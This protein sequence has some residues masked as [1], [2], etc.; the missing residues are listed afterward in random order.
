MSIFKYRMEQCDVS[1]TD[2]LVRFREKLEQWNDLLSGDESHAISGQFADMMWQDAAWRSA[3]EARGYAKEDGPNASVA[4]LIGAL[5][6]RGY[7]AGQVLAIGRLLERSDPKN[8]KRAVVSLRRLVAEIKDARDLITR[9]NFVAN[10]ALPYDYEKGE[11]AEHEKIAA[12]LERRGGAYYIRNP[13]DGPDAWGISKS[14][15]QLFDRLSGVDRDKRSRTDLIQRDFLARLEAYLDD[16]VFEQILDLRNKS[17]AHAADAF[18]RSQTNLLRTGLTMDEIT[19]AHYLLF[20]VYQVLSV[21]FFGVSRGG[22]PVPQHDQFEHLD[23]PF[24][25]AARLPEL[26]KF[27]VDHSNERESWMTKAYDEVFR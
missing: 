10:D 13:T 26:R 2:K 6:D 4:P 12:E 15:H 22:V 27:W 7:V 8:P 24:I 9:E 21:V 16:P 5:L 20:V 14:Q 1:D 17:V 25:R 11:R 19:R 3:N 18:S 23:E